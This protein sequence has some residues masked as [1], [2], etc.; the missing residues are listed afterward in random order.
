MEQ[1]RTQK[2]AAGDYGDS[3]FAGPVNV[4]DRSIHLD[5][6]TRLDPTGVKL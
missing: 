1:M 4:Y 5:N 6:G 3:D 2:K